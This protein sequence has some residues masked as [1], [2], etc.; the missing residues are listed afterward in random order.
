MFQISPSENNI[1]EFYVY[2][3]QE[4]QVAVAEMEE[5]RFDL[6]WMAIPERLQ[7]INLS[8][9]QFQEYLR[10]LALIGELINDVIYNTSNPTTRAVGTKCKELCHVLQKLAQRVIS[11]IDRVE[12][13]LIFCDNKFIALH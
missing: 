4:Y 2:L 6:K 8:R 3:Y 9:A 5:M 12:S 11:R 1:E 13:N 10:E 7:I